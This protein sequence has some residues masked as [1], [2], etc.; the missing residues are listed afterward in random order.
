MGKKFVIRSAKLN[1][2]Y[3]QHVCE[4]RP[5]LDRHVTIDFKN[6]ANES[7]IRNFNACD[8]FGTC[9]SP[10][11][12]D[13]D[14]ECKNLID[15]MEEL[16]A[17]ADLPECRFESIIPWQN[18]N[19]TVHIGVE[20]YG[21]LM[22]DGWTICNTGLGIV[23]LVDSGQP[24]EDEAAEMLQKLEE[25]ESIVD[26]YMKTNNISE[27]KREGLMESVLLWGGYRMEDICWEYESTEENRAFCAY[28]QSENPS[29]ANYFERG[30]YVEDKNGE[31]IDLSYMLGINKALNGMY[32]PFECVSGT[33][34]EDRGMYNG[35]LEACRQEPGQDTGQVLKT[36][37]EEFTGD[38]YDE[39]GRYNEY[40]NVVTQEARDRY[41][42]DEYIGPDE[43]SVTEQNLGIIGNTIKI[44]LQER[45]MYDTDTCESISREFIRQLGEDIQKGK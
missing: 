44:E 38:S 16:Q 30:L 6:M 2:Q 20:G 19:D 27:K 31:T 39:K 18:S 24:D 37:L 45:G 17:N 8:G 34:T 25:L 1:C 14:V 15:S 35:Y 36:F 5:F 4:L 23:T 12:I 9:R 3:G 32:E 28:L 26:E 7:D 10:Y 43:L 11:R 13:L 22:E 42:R 33:M 29:L 40:V 21:A 41:C